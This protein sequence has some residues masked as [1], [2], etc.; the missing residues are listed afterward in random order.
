[1]G[2]LKLSGNGVYTLRLVTFGLLLVKGNLSLIW[3]RREN[4]NQLK[5]KSYRLC[6]EKMMMKVEPH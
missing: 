5:G 4:F 2:R 6:M 3:R 1:M